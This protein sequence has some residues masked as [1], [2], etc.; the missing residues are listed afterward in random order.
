MSR[1]PEVIINKPLQFLHNA[2]LL[3]GVMF[4]LGAIVGF[5]NGQNFLLPALISGGAF[6]VASKIKYRWDKKIEIGGYR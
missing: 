2:F 5:Q 1:T 3:V 4:A 6:L